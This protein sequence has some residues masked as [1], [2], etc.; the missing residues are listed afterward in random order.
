MESNQT[1]S[2]FAP[3]AK[4]AIILFCLP[5]IVIFGGDAVF[6]ISNG[7]AKFYVGSTLLYLIMALVCILNIVMGFR[8]FDK[9]TIKNIFI[10]NIALVACFVFT[11]SDHPN[12]AIMILIA[13]LPLLPLG[14]LAK[15]QKTK[16]QNM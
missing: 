14:I 9:I 10:A 16:L 15:H 7:A 6:R 5:A 11:L 2:G 13:A 1:L 3:Y 4:Y 12:A 8:S